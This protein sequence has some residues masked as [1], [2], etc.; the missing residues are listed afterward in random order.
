MTP[1]ERT[2]QWRA[3]NPGRNYKAVKEWRKANPDFTRIENVRRAAKKY[4]QKATLTIGEWREIVNEYEGLC[5]YCFAPYEH[6]DHIVPVSKGGAS[7]KE[8]VVPA[9]Q[10]CNLRKGS[11]SRS[12]WVPHIASR[13]WP[14][15]SEE[16][17]A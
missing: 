12:G 13:F 15:L 4:G 5:A 7:S 6:L 11:G 9:C 17:Y 10:N 1:A 16:M 2:A 8:N 3:N 14:R